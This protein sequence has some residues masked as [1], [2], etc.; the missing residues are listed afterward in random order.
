VA[1]RDDILQELRDA[2]GNKMRAAHLLRTSY[3]SPYNNY[4]TAN[5][6]D[7]QHSALNRPTSCCQ[8]SIFL[9]MQVTEKI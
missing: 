8:A 4:G 9:D 2:K 6:R 5:F 1:N 7:S 3:S